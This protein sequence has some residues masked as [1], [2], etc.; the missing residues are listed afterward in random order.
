MKDLIEGLVGIVVGIVMFLFYC[1]MTVL[2]FVIGIWIIKAI[3]N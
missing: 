2:P 3:F 1:V